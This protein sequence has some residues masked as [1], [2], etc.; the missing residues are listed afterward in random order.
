M[1]FKN[2]GPHITNFFQTNPDGVVTVS[3]EDVEAADLAVKALD[4][5]LR[6]GRQLSCST[7]DGK[8][9]FRRAE[10]EEERRRREEAWS[11]FLGD[12]KGSDE[13]EEDEEEEKDD[14]NDNDK[15][16]EDEQE[17]GDDQGN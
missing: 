2:L 16:T 9:K 1:L 8:T 10:T 17:E 15:S 3:F 12:E 7:W 5:T 4:R 14:D 6:H 11:K 13:E